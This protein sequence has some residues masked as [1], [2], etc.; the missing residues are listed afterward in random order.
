MKDMKKQS[1][2]T[3]L[4]FS[5]RIA[6]AMDRIFNYPLT[7]VEAPMGYG[8]TTAVREHLRNAKAKFLMQ[9]VYESTT[10]GFWK[11]FC[12]LF[13]ELDSNCSHGLVQLEFPSDS[14][15]LHQAL[16]LIKDIKLPTKTVLFIDDYHLVNETG[17]G[18]FI[19]F[20]VLNE[21]DNLH[22]VLAA[23]FIAL[24][25]M[26]ELSLKG[27]LFHIKN[28]T[29]E[30]MTEEIIEYYR[31]CGI[32]LKKS[33][34]EKLYSSTEGWI[35][36]LYLLMLNFKATGSFTTTD[37]IYR[38]IE[39]NIYEPFSED[40]KDFLLK[41]CIF[42]NFTKE[43]AIYI[44]GNENAVAF[45]AEI[46]RRNAFV[47][48]D[49]SMKIYHIHSIF[50][51]FL[52][53]MFEKKDATYKKNLFQKAGHWYLKSGEHFAAMNYFYTAGDFENLLTVMELDRGSS[54]GYEHKELII[55]FFDECP[56]ELKERHINAL[57]VFA[58]TSIELNE[59]GLYEKI[60]EEIN[61]LLQ[62]SSLD[63]DS[64]NNMLGEL[65]LLTSLTHYNDITR[66]SEHHKKA[67]KLLKKPSAFIDNKG[68]W[69]FGSPSVLYL[70]Y[71]ESGKLEQE[72][73]HLR[74]AMPYY[75]RLTNG[76]GMGAE[77]V[78]VAER[79]FNQGGFV[80]AEIEVYKALHQAR[81]GNQPII[82]ICALFLL[83][84]LA[85]INGEYAC[86]LDL[87][88][89]MHE[90]IELRKAYMLIHTI[91]V[92]KGFVYAY[93]QQKSKIPQW[94]AE[95]DYS[96]S[97][98]YFPAMGF[99]NIIYGRVLLLEGEYLKLL[100][101][102]DHFK[103][104]ASVFP[105]VLA[106]I[107][108]TI[109]E[110]VANDRIQRR[111]PAIDALRQ[112]LDLALPDKVY[113]PFVENCDSI[114]PLLEELFKQGIYRKD[115]GRILEIYKTYQKAM[116]GMQK[117][118]FEESK[119]RLTARETEIAQL[120]AAGLSNKGIGQRLFISENTVKTQLKS[121]FEKLGVDSRSLLKQYFD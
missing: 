67:C 45:L 53:D 1:K 28:D 41:I 66:M 111:R 99:P 56:G 58:L 65:E 12:S 106:I 94:L 113:M 19:E 52:H 10:N 60:C 115:I 48:Y 72:V 38:L 117:K 9:R 71:R 89:K 100:G 109:Y 120:A 61:S 69:T 31:L 11:G 51:N 119:P 29:F 70:Y 5:R 17:A 16:K 101:I 26:E 91:D 116:E 96:S 64:Y 8:K 49:V 35:S 110:A 118:Y 7:V 76:H 62:S 54:F 42:N 22:I 85:L 86:A 97:R 93:L 77:Y 27:Y 37:N 114:K 78:M 34:G 33:E 23:R 83:A 81:S 92:C 75:Y 95:G 3:N 14:V 15:S 82:I 59:M 36:A 105:N 98:L 112:A 44:M 13:H 73:Q 84:R 108:S 102:M 63:P 74:E 2:Q 43:Q 88:N 107:Y 47:N 50:L 24:P 39:K 104:I 68:S 40:I 21:I 90:E 79:H 55:K 4:Y 20:I 87:F 46:I 30:L 6:E 18:K 25:N 32:N 121:V 103:G 80:S 57:L